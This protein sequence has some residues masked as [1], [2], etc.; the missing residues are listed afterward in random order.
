MA[1]LVWPSTTWGGRCSSTDRSRTLTKRRASPCRWYPRTFTGK[2]SFTLNAPR[3][4]YVGGSISPGSASGSAAK[5]ISSC[6][7]RPGNMC[8]WESRWSVSSMSPK[9]AVL[10]AIAIGDYRSACNRRFTRCTCW[11]KWPRA[12]SPGINDFYRTRCADNWPQQWRDTHGH[13]SMT[14][15]YQLTNTP[16]FELPGQDFRGLF[17]KPLSFRRAAADYP[18][19]SIRMIENYCRCVPCRR[20]TPEG[21][22]T[23]CASAPGLA[24]P[25]DGLREFES[26]R[27]DMHTFDRILAEEGTAHDCAIA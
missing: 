12:L 3:E 14:D 17:E 7:P 16:R 2:W 23:S 6:A 9:P 11:S 5:G 27:A 22:S 25:G 18:S 15:W 13:G 20:A 21:C 19:V 8:S 4:G 10:R 1:M 24:R 26:D